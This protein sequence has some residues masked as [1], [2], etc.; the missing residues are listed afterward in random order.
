MIVSQFS[1]IGIKLKFHETVPPIN[2]KLTH[3][4]IKIIITVNVQVFFK[5]IAN[6][7]QKSPS[8]KYNFIFLEYKN[9]EKESKNLHC[10]YLFAFFFIKI[11]GDLFYYF[12]PQSLASF[13][14]KILEAKRI[15]NSS[16]GLCQLR[17]F[18]FELNWLLFVKMRQF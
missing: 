8:V 13:Q 2:N 17:F 14:T 12:F 3:S 6:F 15:E 7:L 9:R 10:I 1:L 18:N 5:K 16:N 11:H 4:S